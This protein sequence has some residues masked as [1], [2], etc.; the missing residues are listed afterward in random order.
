MESWCY[1]KIGNCSLRYYTLFKTI[2]EKIIYARILKILVELQYE[3]K[4]NFVNV[5]LYF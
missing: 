4:I 2:R 1:E 3:N 5:I